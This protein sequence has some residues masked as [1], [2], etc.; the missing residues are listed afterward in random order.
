RNW[1]LFDPA[2]GVKK[3]SE[4]QLQQNDK[5]YFDLEAALQDE[6]PTE[7]T[8]SDDLENLGE[9]I[10]ERM[11]GF[12][13]IFKEIQQ[14]EPEMAGDDNSLFHFNLGTAFQKTGR[15]DEAIDELEKALE[16][17]KRSVDC[18]LRLAVCSRE[19]NLTND[20]IKYLKK[21]LGSENLTESKQIELQYELAEAYKTKGKT[22]KARKIFKQIHK[23][24]DNF[25]AV[26]KELS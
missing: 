18:Y 23:I 22:R 16:N 3:S 2:T 12:E 14:S 15:I 7:E 10:S 25:R 9:N 6:F 11:P 19:K 5:G 24:N 1:E 13:E 17:P 4:K 20:A 26:G 8:I 21:G